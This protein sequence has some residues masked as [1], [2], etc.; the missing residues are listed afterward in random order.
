MC[1]LLP[2]TRSLLVTTLGGDMP[3]V[4]VRV[5]TTPAPASP[6]APFSRLEKRAE[7][8]RA[9][10]ALEK[11]GTPTLR[12][13]STTTAEL[14]A[15]IDA[16]VGDGLL[17][18]CVRA[19]ASLSF[20]SPR[21]AH[22]SFASP[23][24]SGKS[25]LFL[26]SDAWA[27]LPLWVVPGRWVLPR[28]RLLGPPPRRFASQASCMAH[29]P[30]SPGVT[31][32]PND[33]GITMPPASPSL[34]VSPPPRG[35]RCTQ[36]PSSPHRRDRRELRTLEGINGDAGKGDEEADVDRRRSPCFGLNV[37]AADEVCD[38]AATRGN[39][40]DDAPPAAALLPDAAADNAAP[41][42]DDPP[43]LDDDPL[44]G[45]GDAAPDNGGDPPAA[46]PVGV[47]VWGRLC[48]PRPPPLRFSRR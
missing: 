28:M 18:V 2:P 6:R 46:P 41:L 27:P 26:L 3:A 9:A 35:T 37:P 43:P 36:S 33:T 14:V 48:R 11:N 13:S 17:R 34:H 47:V 29:A 10:A 21:G 15:A 32:R 24:R 19:C 25:S 20:N 42:P 23:G 8:G 40:D 44:D 38:V 1:V 22:A 45:E 5:S 4:W 30:R 12:P 16:A 7:E 39:K 31:R